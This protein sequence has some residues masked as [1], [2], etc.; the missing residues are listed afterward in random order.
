APA[1]G[2]QAPPPAFADVAGHWARDAIGA[3]AARGLVGGVQAPDGSLRFEPDRP[4]RR[5][6]AA[7]LL[8]RVIGRQ[9]PSPAFASRLQDLAE[10][11]AAANVLAL[12]EAGL[13]AGVPRDGGLAFE[14]DRSLTRAEALALLVRIALG[15]N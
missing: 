9:A 11:W 8:S 6:E 2:G 4:V 10:H 15:G 3:L 13:V 14:P 1:G 5:G 12:E 7:A